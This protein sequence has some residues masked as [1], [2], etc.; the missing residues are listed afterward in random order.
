MEQTLDNKPVA[1]IK[2]PDSLEAIQARI[3][4][5]EAN[6]EVGKAHR[7]A[8]GPVASTVQ[9]PTP[10]TQA[11]GPEVKPPA[12]PTEPKKDGLEQFKGKDGIVDDGKIRKSNEHLERGIRER[13]ELLRKNKE[14]L[15]KFTT[16]SQ[17]LAETRKTAETLPPIAPP[18][19]VAVDADEAFLRK[20]AQSEEQ[21]LALRDLMREEFGAMIAP[22]KTQLM[23]A[24]QEADMRQKAAELQEIVN[25]GNTWI[26]KDGHVDLSPFDSV[27]TERPYL[28]QSRTPYLDALKFMDVPS[29]SA[30]AP[31]QGGTPILGGGSAVPPPS[32]APAV[33]TEQKMNELSTQFRNLLARG[34]TVEAGKVMEEMQRLNRGY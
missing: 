9:E 29:G 11:V 3:K 32:S 20:L 2:G 5:A 16:V 28:L 24:A 14:L 23:G 18:P 6:P 10:P 17:G 30:S 31:A 21:P 1:P 22:Y 7:L 19:P 4:A 34:Q 15:A 27:F 12:P 26:I 13:E 25:A 8:T 33:T